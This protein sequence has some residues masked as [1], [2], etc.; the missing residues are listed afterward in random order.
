M[1]YKN[2]SIEKNNIFT[3]KEYIIMSEIH[4][5]E[6]VSQRE[7]SKKLGISVSTVNI[8]MNKMISEGLVKMT[9]VSKKQ[10]IYMLTPVGIMEKAKKTVSYIKSHYRAIYKMKEKVKFEIEELSEIHD[11]IFIFALDKEIREIFSTSLEEIGDIKT[12]I[13]FLD[14]ATEVDIKNFK[15]PVL[16]Y[17]GIGEEEL[18]EYHKV[19]GLRTVCLG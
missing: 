9:L 17:M 6:N 3:D 8:L 16:L 11:I 1:T 2:I 4:D 10:V 18:E 5:N 12:D 13:V 19:E 7:L 14:E 15:A